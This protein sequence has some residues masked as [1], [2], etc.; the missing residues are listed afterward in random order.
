[1]VLYRPKQLQTKLEPSELEYDGDAKKSDIS[2]WVTK[3]Y[4]GL[5]G[6]RTVDNS[7]DFGRNVVVAYFDVDY[8]KNAKGTNYWRN[9][10]MKVAKNFPLLKFAVSNKDDFMQVRLKHGSPVNRLNPPSIHSPPSGHFPGL[11]KCFLQVPQLLCS[12][13]AA[14][15]SKGNSQKIVYKTWE[16]T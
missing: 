14:Q 11:V 3:N 8:V 9:R 2:A 4:H 13:P 16:T 5:V 10:V 15:A 12:F 6:H 7:K 1:M